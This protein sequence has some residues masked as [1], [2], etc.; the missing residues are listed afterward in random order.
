[1]SDQDARLQT[2]TITS[3]PEYYDQV[4]ALSSKLLNESWEQL[5]RDNPKLE[6]IIIDDGANGTLKG[7]LNPCQFFVTG[8]IENGVHALYKVRFKSGILTTSGKHGQAV[9]VTGW[10]IAIEVELDN[11]TD[12]D[13]TDDQMKSITKYYNFPAKGDAGS[14]GDYSI[15][16]VF[17]DLIN[18]NMNMV[19]EKQST[20]R[21]PKTGQPCTWRELPNDIKRAVKGFLDDWTLDQDAK[22]YNTLGVTLTSPTYEEENPLKPS[23]QPVSVFHQA[24]KYANPSASDADKY[25]C[26]LLCEL[27]AGHDDLKWKYI[28]QE[29]AS[30][31]YPGI[32]ATY[33]I[34]AHVILE[35]FL[36]L[37]LQPLIRASEVVPTETDVWTWSYSHA[38]SAEPITGGEARW[39]FSIGYNS[40]HTEAADDYFK[41]NPVP[42]TPNYTWSKT[43]KG[44][45]GVHW[46]EKAPHNQGPGYASLIQTGTT[47]INVNPAVG[48][49]TVSVSASITYGYEY[50]Y[51]YD[52]SDLASMDVIASASY[53]GKWMLSLSLST[54]QSG[55]LCF[56]LV[57]SPSD[58]DPHVKLD[59]QVGYLWNDA[60]WDTDIKTLL[61]TQ[62]HD[63]LTTAEQN[64]ANVF[65]TTGKFVYPCNGELSFK[66]PMFNNYGDLLAEVAYKAAPK[67]NVLSPQDGPKLKPY[68]ASV[69]KSLGSD[70]GKKAPKT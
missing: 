15:T 23:Y 60:S 5:W 62:L 7:K 63:S 67:V 8:N 14:A 43:N 34:S 19:N 33:A 28:T 17:V 66:N 3:P 70:Q 2:T 26:L 9:D 64:L 47:D 35:R 20:F 58:V 59:R 36:G 11:Q 57:G 45:T 55:Q 1:M 29:K 24:A 4:L 56:S 22:G 46:H 30:W 32:D 51:S 25:N 53:S 13:M 40:A 21:D 39:T 10:E 48:S 38:A 12:D 49:H 50:R 27:L 41:L 18:A 37:H 16:R 31:C 68:A 44:E 42:N 65:Q 54:D 69:D 52:T 6:D 61:K